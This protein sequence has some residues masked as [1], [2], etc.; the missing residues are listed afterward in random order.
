[1]PVAVEIYCVE[2]YYVSFGYS[3]THTLRHRRLIFISGGSGG[4]DD[5]SDIQ[6]QPDEEL[7]MSQGGT[8]SVPASM[9]LDGVECDLT[10]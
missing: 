6:P 7:E 9:R 4:S 8:P 2:S 3:F 1:M 10:G 5:N